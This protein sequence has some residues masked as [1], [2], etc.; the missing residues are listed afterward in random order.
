MC[1]LRILVADDFAPW[2]LQAQALL[3]E[4]PEWQLFEACDGLEAV[5]KAVELHPD[6]IL[7]DIGMPVLNGIEAAEAIQEAAP[8]SK[9]IFVTEHGDADLKAGALATGAKAYLLKTNAASELLPAIT[10]VLRDGHLA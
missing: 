5:H 7:L 1:T 8:S 9:I 2:R 4:R 10:A 6:I 3:Q